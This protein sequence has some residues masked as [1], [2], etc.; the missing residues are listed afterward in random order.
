LD[1]RIG[2]EATFSLLEKYWFFI[3]KSSNFGKIFWIALS[4]MLVAFGAIISFILRS[5][6]VEI[7]ALAMATDSLLWVNVRS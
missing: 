1:W 3:G 6:F 4:F 2:R 7:T 5:W